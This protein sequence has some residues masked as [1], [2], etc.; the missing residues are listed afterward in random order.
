VNNE[1]SSDAVSSNNSTKQSRQLKYY[2]LNREKNNKME[3]SNDVLHNRY[4]LFNSV[5]KED[6]NLKKPFLSLFDM[7]NYSQS[8]LIH[9]RE[10]IILIPMKTSSIFVLPEIVDYI[11]INEEA[12]FG[13]L[14]RFFKDKVSKRQMN[15][16]VQLL[17][18][19]KWLIRRGKSDFTVYYPNPF[20]I[21]LF[22]KNKQ[23]L[24]LSE[25]A[26]LKIDFF[27]L[28]NLP[29]INALR[30][31]KKIMDS[32]VKF[33]KLTMSEAKPW[34]RAWFNGYTNIT[35][36][37]ETGDI[38][39]TY[40][41][42]NFHASAKIEWLN[43]QRKQNPYGFPH[44][45]LPLAWILFDVLECR[46]YTKKARVSRRSKEVGEYEYIHFDN[47]INILHFDLKTDYGRAQYLM[48]KKPFDYAIKKWN[49]KSCEYVE[50]SSF[51]LLEKLFYCRF[52]E[53]KIGEELFGSLGL[54]HK[55]VTGRP[56]KI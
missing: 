54:E 28:L 56:K 32:E 4:S 52:V 34:V 23:N 35:L 47:S 37:S 25:Y 8:N 13:E 1:I 26:R 5:I 41:P 36:Q 38:F 12:S 14:E 50:V 43:G 6:I 48:F 31:K 39:Q 51:E 30:S 53:N 15:R 11:T 9:E 19:L 27:D 29:L 49:T 17:V 18:N 42:V 22:D 10:D 45:T 33:H 21:A 2:Y 3:K 20:L 44:H 7:L 16:A 55:P 24:L 46:Q 40:L